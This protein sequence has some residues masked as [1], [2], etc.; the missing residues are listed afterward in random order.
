MDPMQNKPALPKEE[1]QSWYS[2][3]YDS[4]WRWIEDTYLKYFGENRASYG[5]KETLRKGQV[6][7]NKDVD[8]IQESAGEAVGNLFGSKGPA[9]VVGE[10]VDKNLL[11]GNM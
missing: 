6:T 1:Q 8:G 4:G 7:G 3:Y 10:G 11:R 5:V 2:G 9:G